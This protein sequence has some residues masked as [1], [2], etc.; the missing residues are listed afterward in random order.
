MLGPRARDDRHFTRRRPAESCISVPL[1]PFEF[2]SDREVGSPVLRVARL[3]ASRGARGTAIAR[4]EPGLAPSRTWSLDQ[5]LNLTTVGSTA[6]RVSQTHG[7]ARSH[8]RMTADPRSTPRTERAYR[9]SP[10]ERRQRIW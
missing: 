1:C 10:A 6:S 7:T 2:G 3:A 5:E 4:Q 8:E 9:T